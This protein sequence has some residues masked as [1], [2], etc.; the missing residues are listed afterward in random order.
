MHK[1]QEHLFHTLRAARDFIA[2]HADQLGGVP[3]SGMRKRL[4]EQ[5]DALRVHIVAQSS[6]A[7]GSRMC[8]QSLQARRATLIEDHM[9]PIACIACAELRDHPDLVSFTVPIRRPSPALLYASAMGMAM[10]AAPHAAVFIDA[11]L[12][13]D[14]I[15]RLRDAANAM[16]DAVDSRT[17]ERGV[18]SGSTAGIAETVANARR[19]VRALN[20]LV[21][22]HIKYDAGLLAEW[23]GARHVQK[24]AVHAVKVAEPVVEQAPAQVAEQP[25]AP[26]AEQ[27]AAAIVPQVAPEATI[28][29]RWPALLLL[30][31]TARKP[32]RAA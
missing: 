29:E 22:I 1:R 15:D 17:R 16:R 20:A 26:L 9:R 27:P 7:L 8:T 32:V 23:D 24:V 28:F 21:R 12:P 11:G 13:P 25:A 18:R 10:A 30:R 6:A 3:A 2:R 31:G 4:D 19:T 14:F 5:I